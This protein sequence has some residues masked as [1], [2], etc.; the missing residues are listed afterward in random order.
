MKDNS[1][2]PHIMLLVILSVICIAL[3]AGAAI[4]AG[5]SDTV[6]FDF[7]NLNLANMLPVLIFGGFIS[8]VIVG[9]TTLFAAKSI[10]SKV[11]EYLSD[12][13]G[14]NKE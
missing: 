8:C 6:L 10:F 12:N 4:F 9:I 7:E 13:K 2:F 3:T 5:F 1:F 11:R 14:G